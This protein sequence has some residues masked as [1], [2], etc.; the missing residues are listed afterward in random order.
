M[1]A[2]RC[3]ILPKQRLVQQC[4]ILFHFISLHFILNFFEVLESI[5]RCFVWVG[6]QDPHRCSHMLPK[7]SLIDGRGQVVEAKAGAGNNKVG[8]AQLQVLLLVHLLASLLH[9]G[10]QTLPGR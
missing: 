8:A 10:C 1:R 2:N 5:L 4:I 6:Q 7:S 3:G 9:F